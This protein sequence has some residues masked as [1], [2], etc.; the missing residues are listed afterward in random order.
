M[1]VSSSAPADSVILV[2][3]FSALET[4]TSNFFFSGVWGF[5]L[6]TS[7]FLESTSFKLAE[8]S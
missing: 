6:E 7:F 8:V 5:A 3:T 2:T 4:G 1:I